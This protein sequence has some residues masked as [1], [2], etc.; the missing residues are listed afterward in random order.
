MRVSIT[1]FL[2]FAPS[3]L[4][5]LRPTPRKQA[6]KDF[7]SLSALHS[8]NVSGDVNAFFCIFDAISF[9]PFLA[10]LFAFHICVSG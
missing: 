6:Y 1:R 7:R 8:I 10:M 4:G 9:K 2:L 5:T 3:V